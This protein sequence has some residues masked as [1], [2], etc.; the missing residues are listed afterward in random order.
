MQP[1]IDYE[2]PEPEMSVASSCSELLG[3]GT[4]L[5]QFYLNL[6]FSI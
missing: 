6:K 4:P 1:T 2:T 3:K 5:V